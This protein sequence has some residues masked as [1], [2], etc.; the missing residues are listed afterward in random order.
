M[1]K[2]NCRA[3]RPSLI[4]AVFFVFFTVCP[5][6]SYSVDR[7]VVDRIVAIVNDELIT[8]TML[9]EAFKPFEKKIRER[10]YSLEQEIEIRYKLRNNLIQQLIDQQLTEQE[11]RRSK[12]EVSEEEIS[13]Y[14]ER[15]K[16]RNGFT[17]EDL[18]KMLETEGVSIAQYRKE[19][20]N[21]LLRNKLIQYEIN[22]KIVI[23]RE[24]IEDYY[25]AN[26]DEFGD[27]PLDEVSSL[28]MDTLFQKQADEKFSRWISALREQSQIKII[29]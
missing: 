4:M 26:K 15:I 19:I 29:Q 5:T 20:R 11:M 17:E 21:L 18:R 22:S 13:L 14:I 23:T 2:T 7:E 25:N 9:T 1:G 3:G 10:N 8:Y 27:K 28:I 16:E 12:I 6:L 24:D